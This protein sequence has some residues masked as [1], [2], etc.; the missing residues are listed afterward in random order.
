MDTQ[1][2]HKRP[3]TEFG[4]QLYAIIYAHGM[5][6]LTDLSKRLGTDGGAISRQS[7]A[8][9]A[10][11]TRKVPSDLPKRLDDVLGLTE[12]ERVNLALAAAY[13]QDPEG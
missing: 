11:G 1:S 10:N 5:R 7:L 12:E 6:S 13:G 3:V 2:R 9:Y 8:A 4:A